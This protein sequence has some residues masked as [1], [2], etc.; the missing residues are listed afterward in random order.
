MRQ[1]F[2]FNNILSDP[3]VLP[4]GTKISSLFYA[5]VCMYVLLYVDVHYFM[6]IDI[7]I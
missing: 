6:Q 7:S 3:F 5:D 2:S 1:T 4:N